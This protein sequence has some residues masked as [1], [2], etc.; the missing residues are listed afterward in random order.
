MSTPT[1][2]EPVG[3]PVGALHGLGRP[4]VRAIVRHV[5]HNLMI[6]TFVPSALFYGCLVTRSLWT[7]LIV[8]LL[9]CYGTLAWR[10]RTGRPPSLLLL[11]SVTGL[12]GK[13]VLALS[14]GS[15]T[16][17]FMQPAVTDALVAAAFLA[18][19]ATTRPA[20]ARFAAEF[21][22]MTKELA[23]RPRVE[24]L[25]I[26]LT[27]L[28]AALC[29]LKAV[30]ALWLLHSL[31][32]TTFVAAKSVYAPSTAAIGAALTIVLAVRVASREGLLPGHALAA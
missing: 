31:S 7:A 27:V 32:L 17:Y 18:S 9:W 23:T 22:P 21:Y 5:G 30:L 2:A 24:A 15:T 6:A 13:T 25:F 8:A 10:I 26:R 19:L 11:L 20:V 3:A 28:W 1:S 12:T 14:T 4:G 29:A 16:V